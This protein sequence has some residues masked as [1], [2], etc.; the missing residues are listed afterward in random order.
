MIE[1]PKA[2]IEELL[3]RLIAVS[4]YQ[5]TKAIVDKIQKAID[6]Q[7]DLEGDEALEQIRL[8]LG[9]VEGRIEDRQ[10]ESIQ[11]WAKHRKALQNIRLKLQANIG[12]YSGIPFLITIM[13][14]LFSLF[15][16]FSGQKWDTYIG[17]LVLVLLSLT[18]G[19][20]IIGKTPAI[21][22]VLRVQ[23]LTRRNLESIKK[24]ILKELR[25]CSFIFTSLVLLTLFTLIYRAVD[26]G[27]FANFSLPDTP[28]TASANTT[29]TEI[30]NNTLAERSWSE[31]EVSFPYS[32]IPVNHS[33]EVSLFLN[34]TPLPN[35][36]NRALK[37]LGLPPRIGTNSVRIAE[38][39]EAHLYASKYDFEVIPITP[40]V[41]HVDSTNST[42][43]LWGL[44]SL[45]PGTPSLY[46]VLNAV[47]IINDEERRHTVY[48]KTLKVKVEGS[49]LESFQGFMS[50]YWQWLWTTILIPVVSFYWR[51]RKQ[52]LTKVESIIEVVSR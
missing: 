51:W 34:P 12:L 13:A 30:I 26:S 40:T 32:E 50:E 3:E 18:Y 25:Y 27:V 22:N 36:L 15:N 39:M 10:I 41:Q 52:R 37:N 2:E 16:F 24:G 31:I 35:T 11:K 21:T 20:E 44:N 49:L 14:A 38:V 9:G 7:K 29:V 5:K 47:V 42:K 45:R 43:W 19:R 1:E 33:S 48:A 17:L 23:P 46:L 6:A 28:L 8:I 4:E